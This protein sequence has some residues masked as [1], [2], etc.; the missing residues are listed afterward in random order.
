M[1]DEAGRV[2][3][4]GRIE[5]AVVVVDAVGVPVNVLALA[6]APPVPQL[7]GVGVRRVSTGS[8]PAGAVVPVVPASTISMA[9]TSGFSTTLRRSMSTVPSL[10]TA[11]SRIVSPSRMPGWNGVSVAEVVQREIDLPVV[12]NNDA[13]LMAAGELVAAVTGRLPVASPG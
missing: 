2:E 12:V 8:L 3:L 9:L 5:V 11:T 7:A 4:G 10:V 13:N 1:M 6:T